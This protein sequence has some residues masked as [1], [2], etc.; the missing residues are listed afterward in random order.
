MSLWLSEPSRWASCL[1]SARL[2]FL[3]SRL[4]TLGFSDTEPLWALGPNESGAD[5]CCRVLFSNFL[6]AARFAGEPG[7]LLR[8]DLFGEE[9][10]LFV[11]EAG[12]SE[13]RPR[14]GLTSIVLFRLLRLLCFS[15]LRLAGSPASK[16][17]LLITLLVLWAKGC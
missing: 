9:R 5:W 4:S 3:M 2:R 10:L 6:A 12:Y 15:V 14:S 13:S 1:Q 16:V 17:L 8:P 7:D 11:G